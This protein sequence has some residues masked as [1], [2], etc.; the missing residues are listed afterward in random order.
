MLLLFNYHIHNKNNRKKRVTVV[1]QQQPLPKV[2]QRAP[3]KLVAETSVSA[4]MVTAPPPPQ[5]HEPEKVQEL[6][7]KTLE[8]VARRREQERKSRQADALKPIEEEIEP[9]MV[10]EHGS[11][12]DSSSSSAQVPPPP[13]KVVP[14]VVEHL[15]PPPPPP[16]RKPQAPSEEDDRLVESFMTTL[17]NKGEGQQ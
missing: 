12:L 5:T 6:D 11:F 10:L 16:P 3:K 8:E 4:K 13:R 14:Q 9:W 17:R 2:E 7:P 1:L 15:P